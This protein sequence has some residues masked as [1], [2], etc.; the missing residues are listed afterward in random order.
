MNQSIKKEIHITLIKSIKNKNFFDKKLILLCK[1]ILIQ[2]PNKI[3]KEFIIY[4]N[5]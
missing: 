2:N 3:F 4:K 5:N 1:K